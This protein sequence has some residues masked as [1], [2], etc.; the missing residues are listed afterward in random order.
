MISTSVLLMFHHYLD[1]IL[2]SAAI[3]ITILLCSIRSNSK[4]KD[5]ACV[6]ASVGVLTLS[7]LIAVSSVRADAQYCKIPNIYGMTYD[8]AINSLHEAGLKGRLA[9][10]S[11]NTNLSSADVRVVW[12]SREASSVDS[13]GAVVNFVI[14][15]CFAMEYMPLIREDQE[16]Y[17]GLWPWETDDSKSEWQIVMPFSNISFQAKSVIS[18]GKIATVGGYVGFDLYA[19]SMSTTLEQI[20]I[21]TCH[22]YSPDLVNKKLRF[23]GKLIW[24]E[25]GEKKPLMLEGITTPQL[26]GFCLL[27]AQLVTGKYDFVFGLIDDADDRCYEWKHTISIIEYEEWQERHDGE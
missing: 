27:P 19:E 15:D 1:I 20:A 10:S 6:I 17:T 26:E 13:K 4:Q 16:A 7:I 21:R 14:D 12:Q 22:R 18:G 25:T 23:V 24:Q 3:M 2:A 9:L 11:T 8:D 5:T